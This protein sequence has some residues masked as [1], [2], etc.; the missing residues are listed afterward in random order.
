[1]R[2]AMEPTDDIF[3]QLGARRVINGCGV[4]TDLGGTILSE[5][6][7]AAM[8]A[9]NASAVHMPEL[10]DRS[11]ERIASWLGTE[12][13][14]VTPGA[15]AAIALG[16]AACLTGM[17]GEAWER[18]PDTTG[19]KAEVV[20]Q[21]RHHYKYDRMVR[22]TGARLV[23]AG[24]EAG[25]TL[26]QLE[27]ALGPDTAMLMVP[28]HLDRKPG[29]VP[30][31]DVIA[32]AHRHAVPV[33]VDAA[34]LNY[35]V[36]RMRRFQEAGAD[37][38]CFS[39]KYFYGPNSGGLICGRRDL[40]AA[41]A[42]VDFTRYESGNYLTFGRPFKLDRQIVAGTVAALQAWLTMDHEER[43]AGYAA[44]VDLIAASLRGLPGVTAEPAFFTM[45]ERLEPAPVNCLAVRGAFSP[46]AVADA[47][48]AQDPRIMTVPLGDV[49][50]IAVDAMRDGDEQAVAEQLGAV[51]RRYT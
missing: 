47:L 30:V 8:T 19:L 2:S 6:V 7:W 18:L 14:R 43:W 48:A 5:P 17:D 11:G 20:L 15:S 35:P 50:V 37:L 34:Y 42:G 24:D 4:Y 29:T 16:T 12:A 3:D 46:D 49:L 21:Q 39:A 40:I 23:F 25:T 33:L 26:E 1:M 13:A 45:D 9:I 51:V 32:I 41:V 28:G 22:L 44:K 10:L 36:A 38:V 27:A 31:E